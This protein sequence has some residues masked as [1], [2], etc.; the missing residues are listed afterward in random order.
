ML[1]RFTLFDLVSSPNITRAARFCSLR[2]LVKLSAGQFVQIYDNKCS[3]VLKRLH[4]LPAEVSRKIEETSARRVAPA[5]TAPATC[6]TFLNA[7]QIHTHA[8]GGT[9]P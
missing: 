3:L 5:M 9:V 8:M 1:K 7:M 4:T 2:I 6:M